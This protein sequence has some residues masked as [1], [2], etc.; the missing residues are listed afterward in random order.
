MASYTPSVSNTNVVLLTARVLLPFDRAIANPNNGWTTFCSK[1]IL[2][3]NINGTHE[4][5][6]QSNNAITLA[7][8][9]RILF[10]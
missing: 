8:K 7:K 9:L 10:N 5:M 6:L 1:P 2:T 3:Y 4:S